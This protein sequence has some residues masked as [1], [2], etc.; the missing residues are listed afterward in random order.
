[1]SARRA[2]C[3]LLSPSFSLVLFLRVS[4]V[5]AQTAAAAPPAAPPP[6][7]P[8]AAL[9]HI[10]C[11]KPRLDRKQLYDSLAL[12]LGAQG[13]TLSPLDAITSDDS[14]ILEVRTDCETRQRLILRVARGVRSV[15]ETFSLADLPRSSE[16]RTIALA[17]AELLEDFR[18]QQK[19]KAGQ[20]DNGQG[21]ARVNSPDAVANN[22]AVKS[23][24]GPSLDLGP[25]VDNAFRERPVRIKDT[26]VEPEEDPGVHLL[27]MVGVQQRTFRLANTLVG[28][29]AGFSLEQAELGANLLRGSVGDPK[30]GVSAVLGNLSLG[31]RVAE[32]TNGRWTA[33][34]TPRVGL[35]NIVATRG[36]AEQGRSSTASEIYGDVAARISVNARIWSRIGITLNSEAGYGR[37]FVA[38]ADGRTTADYTG[39]F[40]GVALLGSMDFSSRKT[41]KLWPPVS[42]APK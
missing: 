5:H 2:L 29:D 14:F 6:P 36:T 28:L 26:P 13:V 3:T 21:A 7:L 18:D 8:E 27:A 35:G 1:M 32:V 39:L 16:L 4:V 31:Y 37:G 40:L 41:S 20:D 24:M 9:V 23:A 34:V 33:S 15:E 17:L 22:A 12:E 42:A 25:D 10:D 30:D 11:A 19:Q 38:I